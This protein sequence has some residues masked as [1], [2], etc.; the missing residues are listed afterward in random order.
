[1]KEVHCFPVRNSK[2]N[3]VTLKL[4]QKGQLLEIYKK[5]KDKTNLIESFSTC[6][7]QKFFLGMIYNKTVLKKLTKL[8]QLVLEK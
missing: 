5:L 1:M 2:I 4:H 8:M 3:Q 7:A 6:K